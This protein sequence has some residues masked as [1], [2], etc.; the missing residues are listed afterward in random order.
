M[1]VTEVAAMLKLNL[2]AISKKPIPRWAFLI[3]LV[4]IFILEEEYE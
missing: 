4:T 2:Q 1:A 3:R